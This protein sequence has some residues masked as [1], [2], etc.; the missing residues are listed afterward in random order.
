M[1]SNI[2]DF[3]GFNPYPGI[4]K[5]EKRIKILAIV[6]SYNEE[7]SIAEVIKSIKQYDP[8]IDILVVNDGSNDNTGSVAKTTGKAF[9]INLPCNLGIGGA[10]QAGFK[11]AGRK[12]YDIAFQ[13]DGDGQH[14]ASEIR[15]LLDPVLKNEADVA[16]GSRFCGKT[17]GFQSTMLRRSGIKIFE[18]LNSLLIKQKITDNTSGFRAYCKEAIL[19]LADHYPSDYPEPEAVLLLGR[20]GFRLKEVSVCMQERKEGKSSITGLRSGYYMVKVLLALLV[21]ALR[22]TSTNRKGEHVDKF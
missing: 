22:T 18:I 10:V 12:G 6:P 9:I 21:S 14:L 11:Y 13:F 2:S 4:I 8:S 5:M 16:I 20:N 1:G 17:A 3:N 15:N 19:F 7:N